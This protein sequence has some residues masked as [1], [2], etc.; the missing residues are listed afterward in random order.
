MFDSVSELPTGSY[1]AAHVLDI[2]RLVYY[3]C[4]SQHVGKSVTIFKRGHQITCEYHFTIPD[5]RCHFKK[6]TQLLSI[7][8]A[9]V[10]ICLL[11][12]QGTKNIKT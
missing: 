5:M 3:A 2:L 6:A 1:E 9:T 8:R 12:Y 4:V 7:F 10:A 11:S